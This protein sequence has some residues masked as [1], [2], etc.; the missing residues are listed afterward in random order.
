MWAEGVD[1]LDGGAVR[2]AVVAQCDAQVGGREDRA[3]DEHLDHTCRAERLDEAGD[4]LSRWCRPLDEERV[5]EAERRTLILGKA[6]ATFGGVLVHQLRLGQARLEGAAHAHRRTELAPTDACAPDAD[7]FD[8]GR[9]QRRRVPDPIL[10]EAEAGELL[11]VPEGQQRG[12][13]D[14]LGRAHVGQQVHRTLLIRSAHA[15]RGVG[16]GKT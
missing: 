1:T 11:R 4:L 12:S 8:H 3:G 14:G 15:G 6:S 9:R 10:E 16:R 13:P 2:L 7:G 5:D